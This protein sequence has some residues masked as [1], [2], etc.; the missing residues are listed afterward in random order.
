MSED[1]LSLFERNL[2]RGLNA[3]AIPC[4]VFHSSHICL[5]DSHKG[6]IENYYGD[7]VKAIVDAESFLPRVNQNFHRSFWTCELSELKRASVEC[8]ENW[9]LCGR[10]MTGPIYDCKRNCHFRYKIAL[11]KEKAA[12]LKKRSDAM[13]TDLLNRDSNAFWKKWNS[14]NRVGNNL[15]SRISGETEESGIADVFSSYFKSVYS[16]NDTVEHLALKDEFHDA[17]NKYFND[18]IQD[19]IMCAFLSWT[20]MVEL[21]SK[22]KVGKANAGLVKPE[23]FLYG[24]PRLLQHF[25]IFFNSLIQHGFVPTDFLKGTISPI[26]KD[27][28]GDL[29]DTANYRGITLSSLPS[30]LFEFAIQMKTAHLLSTDDMQFGF[31]RG[32]STSHAL[33]CLRST[34]DHFIENGSRVYAAFLDCSKAFDRISH[35]GLFTKL[36]QRKIPLCFL[37]CLIFWYENMISVVKWGSSYS[38]EFPVPLGIKQGGITSPDF[39]ACYFDGLTCLLREKKLG[40]HIG[41]LFLASIFFADDIVLLSPTRSG[42]QR[43]IDGCSSYCNTYGLTFNAKKSLVMVFS[44]TNVDYSRIQ[45]LTISGS[46]IDFTERT[47]YLGTTIISN[48]SISFSNEDDLKSFYR[49]SNSILNQLQCPDET[50]LMQLLYT[51]CIP[52]FSYACAVKDYTAKQMLECTVAVNNAI[53]RIFTFN[54]WESV[55][56]LR[57]GFGYLSLTEIFAKAKRKFFDSL[58]RHENA[59]I[60]NLYAFVN[61]KL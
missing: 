5:D 16:G 53:R 50:V 39:F 47:R 1:D 13:Y 58:S 17:F 49:A 19:D 31:K 27:S 32:T 4:G 35:Y 26:V 57:E 8:F 37:L 3:I 55:R 9:R 59:T 36:I 34:V 51:H 6:M 52:C 43:M 15:A 61:S 41:A 21:A 28:Q 29:S 44:K 42:L 18:C 2:T 48:R 45:P 33:F 22:I 40:C 25:Q 10:P 46:P 54:R 23:H 11:R 30:K 24:G 14:I 56:A 38:N 12:D 20:D 7:I 60:K